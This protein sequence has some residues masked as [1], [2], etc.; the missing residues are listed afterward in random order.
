[1]AKKNHSETQRQRQN[2][3]NF[4]EKYLK[5]HKQRPPPEVRKI[6]PFVSFSTPFVSFK[7]S[8]IQ[9][10]SWLLRLTKINQKTF[11]LLRKVKRPRA[12]EA[13]AI[14]F[15]WGSNLKKENFQ[16]PTVAEEKTRVVFWD[17]PTT[18][19]CKPLVGQTQ[20]QEPKQKR[21]RNPKKKSGNHQTTRN[22]NAQTNQNP[23]SGSPPGLFVFP[24]LSFA[25]LLKV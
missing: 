23:A 12:K 4:V 2:S 11:P 8:A 15:L 6:R 3:R 13:K 24:L 14:L 7:A 10:L 16:L 17:K 25:G 19:S 21:S 22:P 1:M 5:N 20:T 18:P 9:F